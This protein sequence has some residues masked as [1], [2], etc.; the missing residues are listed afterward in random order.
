M[1]PLA[2]AASKCTLLTTLP[3]ANKS[4]GIVL[5]QPRLTDITVP[6]LIAVMLASSAA[7]TSLTAEPDAIAALPKFVLSLLRI[8]VNAPVPP[9]ADTVISSVI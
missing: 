1:V 4:C 8:T 5:N 2:P 7:L 3:C 6:E 9:P